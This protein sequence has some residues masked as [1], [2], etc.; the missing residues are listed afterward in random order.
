MSTELPVKSEALTMSK[1][2]TVRRKQKQ[3]RSPLVPWW[4]TKT[5]QKPKRVSRPTVSASTTSK[6][7]WD[8]RA[9]YFPGAL[10]KISE[11]IIFVN[12]LSE[13][14]SKAT[15]TTTTTMDLV[16][17]QKLKS[18]KTH[19]SPTRATKSEMAKSTTGPAQV[20]DFDMELPILK[21]D[22]TI[23]REILFPTNS[24]QESLESTQNL[25]IGFSFLG[26]LCSASLLHFT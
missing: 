1:N 20:S 25:V 9:Y 8:A 21:S 15:T 24:S 13:E 3:N 12:P 7:V 19:I 4:R 26:I 5:T 11:A 23:N 14:L 10:P 16:T 6:V 18:S 22:A 2:V 17:T